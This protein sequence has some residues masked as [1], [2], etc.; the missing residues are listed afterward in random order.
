MH[1]ELCDISPTDSVFL[2]E[3]I[4]KPLACKHPSN[5]R[6]QNTRVFEKIWLQNI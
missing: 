2:S 3:K 4:F 6:R 1:Q 5:R